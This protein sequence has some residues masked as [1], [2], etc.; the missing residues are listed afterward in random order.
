MTQLTLRSDA[1]VGS[2]IKRGEKV[3]EI[4]SIVK[5]VEKYELDGVT[6]DE[7]PGEEP[8]QEWWETTVEARELSPEEIA[9]LEDASAQ[10]KREH[11]AKLDRERAEREAARSA[12]ENQFQAFLN[13]IAVG[14]VWSGY[15][16]DHRLYTNI[17]GSP[18]RT[19]PDAYK[20][21][22]VGN[23][24][25]Y[26]CAT[27]ED[28]EALFRFIFS[29]DDDITTERVDEMSRH[30]DSSGYTGYLAGAEYYRWVRAR[31]LG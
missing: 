18:L 22:H 10:R 11:Q 29:V 4:L 24:L 28:L 12:Q 27:P 15:D 23:G 5:Q 26:D 14:K 19:N 17:E 2:R 16:L 8:D 3:Y 31:G 7:Y 25:G 6:Y 9:A 20:G 21:R 1:R 13:G 30:I